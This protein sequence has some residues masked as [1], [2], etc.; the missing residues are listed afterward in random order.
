MC[1][2]ISPLMA[3]GFALKDREKITFSQLLEKRRRLLRIG[4]GFLLD[5]SHRTIAKTVAAYPNMM[6]VVLENDSFAV[7]KK[8]IGQEGRIFKASHLK[9]CYEAAFSAKEFRSVTKVLSEY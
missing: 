5:V 6:E 7:A 4:E 3:L 9:M 2:R 1:K 8:Q